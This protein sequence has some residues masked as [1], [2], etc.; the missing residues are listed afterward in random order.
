MKNILTPKLRI[1]SFVSYPK[2]RNSSLYALKYPFILKK[3]FK[4]PLSK[5]KSNLREPATS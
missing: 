4:M 2:L 1:K 3:F 5:K